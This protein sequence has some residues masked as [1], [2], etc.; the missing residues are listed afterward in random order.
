MAIDYCI[1]LIISSLDCLFYLFA[2]IHALSKSHAYT[3]QE[4]KSC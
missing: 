1:T 2:N 3:S 4:N